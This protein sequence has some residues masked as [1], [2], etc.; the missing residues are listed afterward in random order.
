MCIE[1]FLLW[2]YINRQVDSLDD[3]KTFLDRVSAMLKVPIKY[4]INSGDK[5]SILSISIGDKFYTF[6][7]LDIS[8]FKI[9]PICNKM[10]FDILI[11]VGLCFDDDKC[12]LIGRNDLKSVK[13]SKNI[14][15]IVD[16][17]K[18]GADYMWIDEDDDALYISFHRVDSGF[19]YVVLSIFDRKCATYLTIDTNDAVIRKTIV[20]SHILDGCCYDVYLRVNAIKPNV[21][22]TEVAILSDRLN[23]PIT[24]KKKIDIPSIGET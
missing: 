21:L 12:I 16:I 10:S 1:E 6:N 11:S 19:V 22:D 8:S 15:S 5:D 3:F 20:D 18:L 23:I 7:I 4:E 14:K 17:M 9:I 2:C 13:I 24:I